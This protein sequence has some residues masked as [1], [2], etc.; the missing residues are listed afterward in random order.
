MEMN[1]RVC[2]EGFTHFDGNIDGKHIDSLKVYVL[3]EIKSTG[4]GACGGARTVEYR[5]RDS[6]EVAARLVGLKF[7]AECD[8]T[9]GITSAN[10]NGET[11]AELVITDIKPV[12][13]KQFAKSA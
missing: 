10:R 2:L 9:F 7:P 6:R 1:R 4:A 8:L 13:A 12:G 11:V 3:E 5:M